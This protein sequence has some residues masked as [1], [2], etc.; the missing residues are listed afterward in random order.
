MKKILV[1][2][3]AALLATSGLTFAQDTV[4]IEVPQ[5]ARDY[6]IANPSDPVVIEDELSPGYVVPEDIVIREI[7]ESP[8]Y[9]YIYVD[10]RPVIVSTDNRQVVYLSDAGAPSAGDA[11]PD[12]AITYVEKHPSDPVVFEGELTTG[13]VIPA[14]V[15]LVE[16]PDQPRYSYIYV[17]DRPALIET[18]TRRVVW[19]R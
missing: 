9:G 13:A 19:V 3:A 2:T 6:V 17:D 16:V 7:P 14:D 18:E 5:S 12:E 8:G 11:F 4:V 10:D 15:P 1:L